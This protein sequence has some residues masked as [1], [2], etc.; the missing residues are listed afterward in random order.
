M[1]LSKLTSQ[2]LY[3]LLDKEGLGSIPSDVSL[4]LSEKDFMDISFRLRR[5]IERKG[6]NFSRYFSG[7]SLT[8]KGKELA[9]DLGFYGLTISRYS[10]HELIEELTPN[11]LMKIVN[12]DY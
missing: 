12:G 11:H 6:I 3:E 1:T 9:L 4:G 8:E 2:S 7:G 5:K 10:S